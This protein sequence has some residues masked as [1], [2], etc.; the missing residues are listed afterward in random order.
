[1]TDMASEFQF[2]VNIYERQREV[3]KYMNLPL[4]W[5]PDEIVLE[6]IEAYKYLSQTPASRL[7]ESAYIASEKL[8]SHIES[9]DLNERDRNSKPVW[10]IKQ[11]NDILAMLPKTLE[12]LDNAE[13]QYIKMQETKTKIRKNKEKTLYDGMVLG[14]NI[15]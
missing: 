15:T 3:K 12:S 14:K 11:Y 13:K 2:Q 5:E 4:D 9:I 10:N 8:K 6:A 7:L 1:M